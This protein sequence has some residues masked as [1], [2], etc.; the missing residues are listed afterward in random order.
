[1]LKRGR[2]YQM[3]KEY[4]AVRKPKQKR[5]ELT[6]ERLIEAGLRL[7][8]RDGY[9]ATSAKKIAKEAGISTGNFYNHFM[10]KKDLL[11]E[12]HSR[13]AQH[14]HQVA[15]NTLQSADFDKTEARKIIQMI[16]DNAL[17]AHA[18]APDFHR[19]MTIMRYEDEQIEKLIAEEYD[20]MVQ[21]VIGI[22]EQ[23]KD[24]LRIN[25]LEAAARVVVYSIEEVVHTII[26]LEPPI[27]QGRL[28]AALADM[29][30]CF[31]IR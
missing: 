10:D 31:L 2:T 15:I 3:T 18:I 19:Q 1:M 4:P 9:H 11:I 22:F 29:I 8:S 23:K 5:A 20:Q 7:F 17:K 25:D 21:A 24:I 30:H 26:I 13:Y 16:L 28:T 6:R 27:E 14:A 12:V